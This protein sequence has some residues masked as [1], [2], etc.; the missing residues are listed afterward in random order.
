MREPNREDASVPETR[1]HQKPG[2]TSRIFL[3]G[4]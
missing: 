1:G 4:N 2:K 3:R